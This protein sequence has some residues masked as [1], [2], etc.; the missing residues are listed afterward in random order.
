MDSHRFDTLTKRFV[1]RR[2]GV[3]LGIAGFLG[4]AAPAAEARKKHKNKKRK[5][6]KKTCKSP[7]GLC[8]SCQ[9]GQCSPN[10]GQKPCGAACIALDACC[11]NG[12]PGCPEGRPCTGGACAACSKDGSACSDPQTCCSGVCSGGPSDPGR[13][14]C[15]KKDKP[16]LRDSWC[17]G[18]NCIK[19]QPGDREGVCGCGTAGNLCDAVNECCNTCSHGVCT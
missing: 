5:K 14:M 15:F 13:C 8:E 3:G 2:A 7:C 1:S 19:A 16:C 12:T 11:T 17:C 4:I 9:Q 18:G 10:P 6:K